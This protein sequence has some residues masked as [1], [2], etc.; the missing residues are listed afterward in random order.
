MAAYAYTAINAQGFSLDGEIHAPSLDA[1]RGRRRRS[2]PVAGDG[3]PPEDLHA[4][5]RVDG[6]GRR[7][8]RYP[9]PGPRSDGVPDRARDEAEAPRQGRDDV[10]DD[11]PDLRDPRPRRHAALPGPDL[12]EDLLGPRRRAAEA[13]ADRRVDERLHQAR[14]VA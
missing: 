1:A 10:P 8:R 12:H 9:R 5:V 2:A 14:L 11:G 3:P 6:R 13:D 4:P 7:G